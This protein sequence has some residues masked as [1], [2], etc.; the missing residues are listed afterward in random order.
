MGAVRRPAVWTTG[1]AVGLV[2]RPMLIAPMTPGGPLAGS[3]LLPVGL[4]ALAAFHF[5]LAAGV[6]IE[7]RLAVGLSI[8]TA[9]VGV[10]IAL[11]GAYLGLHQGVGGMPAN[12]GRAL[13]MERPLFCLGWKVH[14]SFRR[15]CHVR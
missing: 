3:F 5:V 6:L 1:L 11:L 14:W 4:I 15:L 12:G 10:P 7:N 8:L 9:V 13:R 2:L